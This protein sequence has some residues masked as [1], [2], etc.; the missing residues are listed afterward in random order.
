MTAGQREPAGRAAARANRART[1][2]AVVERRKSAAKRDQ[3]RTKGRTWARLFFCCCVF[4]GDIRNR[5]RE[6]EREREDGG[7]KK[8]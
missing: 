1:A 5:Q 8:G 4:L 2:A 7:L 6:R 3:A